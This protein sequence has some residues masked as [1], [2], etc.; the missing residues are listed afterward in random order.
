MLAR[1]DY[2]PG[3]PCWVD[4]IQP[5]AD[6]TLAFYGD[7]FGWTYEIRTPEGAP[8]RYAYGLLDGQIV[9][10]VGGPP[11]GETEPPGWTSYVRVESV[12]DAVAAVV[13]NGGRV[14]SPP[15]DIPRSGR[16]AACTDPEGAVFGVWQPAELRG[17]QTV[18]APGSWNFSELHT[19]DPAAAERFY[20]A[21]FGWELE[22]F[23]GNP[24]FGGFWK[25]AGYGEF[26]AERDPEIRERQAADQA[27][28]GFA[29]AV[30]AMQPEADAGPDAPARWTVTFA[31]A[32]ADAA[33]ARAVEL[34]ATTVTPLFDTD[35]TRQ[36]T[37]RDPQGAE[38]TLSEYRPPTS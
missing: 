9:S 32:D 1:D 14:L 37:I 7:L 17:A 5:D 34:G 35:Y 36:G 11:Q 33:F 38:L 20:G 28:G 22:S 23:G 4:L 6:A 3:V 24:G 15:V 10:G 26:L 8:F 12:D 30:A 13:A 31:V 18:N 25:V 19:A 29:D 16:V 21:V 27:P 2:P